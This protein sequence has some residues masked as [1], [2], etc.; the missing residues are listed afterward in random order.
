MPELLFD[1]TQD[2][3][4]SEIDFRTPVEKLGSQTL[5]VTVEPV[6]EAVRDEPHEHF[7]FAD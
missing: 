1:N 2:H 3:E 4:N 7:G 6:S 5:E